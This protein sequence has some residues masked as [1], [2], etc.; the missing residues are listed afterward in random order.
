M[1]G[2][3]RKSS[4]KR[5]SPLREAQRE[6]TRSRIRD[7]AKKVFYDHHF[8]S[9]TMDQIAEA[10]EL[11]RATIY[12]HYKDKGKILEDI[13]DNYTPGAIEILSAL[14]GPAPSLAETVDWIK[15]SAAFAEKELVHLSIFE[16]A[17]HVYPEGVSR[18][19]NDLIMAMGEQ[20]PIFREA[21]RKDASPA[22]R[23]KALL[24]LQEVTYTSRWYCES[25]D[26]ELSEAMVVSTARALTD[27]LSNPRQ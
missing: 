13:I 16:D 25:A 17:R 19:I 2:K 26:R 22:L 11:S 1:S 27:F 4:S 10:A 5:A 12:L 14:P 20:N 18:L 15:K 7:A 3:A 6:L 8:H 9:A 23:A 24:L 21:A